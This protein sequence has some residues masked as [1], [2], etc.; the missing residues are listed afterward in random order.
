MRGTAEELGRQLQFA[1]RN[2]F[3]RALLAG[4]AI[5]VVLIAVRR[6]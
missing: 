1:S 4:G 5:A 2:P 3:V 6:R